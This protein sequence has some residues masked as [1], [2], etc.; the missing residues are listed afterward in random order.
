MKRQ[1][2]AFVEGEGK[3]LEP[4]LD[5]QKHSMS[6]AGEVIRETGSCIVTELIQERHRW[7][8]HV[9]RM[10]QG[11]KPSHLLKAVL[12][13]RPVSWWRKQ[14]ICNELGQNPIV[15]RAKM[16]RVRKWETVFDDNW[17]LKAKPHD[18]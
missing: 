5:W 3:I 6:R 8:E 17:I 16:G 10:G 4:W 11:D 13:F 2:I 15:H 18:P 1:P 7:S 12:M 14:Q 9:A